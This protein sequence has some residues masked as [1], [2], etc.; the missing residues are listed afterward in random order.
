MIARGPDGL[1]SISVA[2]P[3]VNEALYPDSTRWCG[4]AGNS[5]HPAREVESRRR[6]TLTNTRRSAL[7]K[8]VASRPAEQRRNGGKHSGLT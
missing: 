3:Q 8:A 1:G 2:G 4:A 7:G 5:P 6:F